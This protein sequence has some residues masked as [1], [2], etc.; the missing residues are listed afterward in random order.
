MD[1]QPVG[2][3]KPTMKHLRTTLII[4]VCLFA[5]SV[6]ADWSPEII[7]W[8]NPPGTPWAG[9]YATMYVDSSEGVHI[10]F[11][12]GLDDFMHQ[13]LRYFKFDDHGHQIVGPVLL[14]DT[15]DFEIVNPKIRD[16]GHD[17][18]L[19]MYYW[20]GRIPP[21]NS[22][23]SRTIRTDGTLI[24]EA[25]NWTDSLER[26]DNDYAF[27][28]TTDGTVALATNWS[29]SQ[30]RVSVFR[31]DGTQPLYQTLVWN[32]IWRESDLVNG[33]VD[34]QDTLQL[35]WRERFL[36]SDVVYTKR[37]S[38]DAPC[39]SM[40]VADHVEL[41]SAG[42][43]FWNSFN[44]FLPFGDSLMLL[45]TSHL[46]DAYSPVVSLKVLRKS[47]YETVYSRTLGLLTGYSACELEGDSSVCYLHTSNG[48]LH[49]MYY[50]LPQLDSLGSESLGAADIIY[51]YQQSL[52][53]VRHVLYARFYAGTRVQIIYRYW[54]ADL[55]V[56][57]PSPAIPASDFML[58]PNPT[59]GGLF[60]QGPMES[61]KAISVFN[62]LGQEVMSL[63][64]PRGSNGMLSLPQ[65]DALSTG[66]YFLKLHT[67]DGETVKK[68]V[69]AR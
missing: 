68:F 60:V 18:L 37:A 63:P 5:G 40:H 52:Q 65:I 1:D 61:V 42:Q 3:N 67:R 24:G 26:P 30:I 55:P 58:Y 51:A 13:G 32:P 53:G 45:A 43:Y 54:R 29:P 64:V 47:N 16:C 66:E 23:Q 19:I 69:V 39:D 4:A 22:F 25:R 56:D 31:P 59:N 49:L 15:S 14:T 48:Q 11:Q 36:D 9:V 2:L 41:A 57:E 27:D 8:D 50:S 38:I 12:C 21:Y 46:A 7:L 20:Y 17:S 28:I 10:A 34:S 6:W 62:V 33:F 44:R 35:I